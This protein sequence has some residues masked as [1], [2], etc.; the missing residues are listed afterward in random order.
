MNIVDIM[1]SGSISADANGP[2]S[3]ASSNIIGSVEVRKLASSKN[4][5]GVMTAN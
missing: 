5:A 3:N 1:G 2:V 4:L